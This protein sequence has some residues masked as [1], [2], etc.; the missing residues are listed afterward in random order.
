MEAIELRVAMDRVHDDCC[1]SNSTRCVRKRD[2]VNRE[3]ITVEF[4]VIEDWF[5]HQS[6]FEHEQEHRF[7]E[8][9]HEKRNYD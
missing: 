6:P 5:G 4:F 9:E 7:A 2:V 8:H 3:A 1:R